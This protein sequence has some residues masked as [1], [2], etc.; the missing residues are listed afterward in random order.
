MAHNRSDSE[1]GHLKHGNCV[2]VSNN[3]VGILL[4]HQVAKPMLAS[5]RMRDIWTIQNCP[6]WDCLG[7]L[8]RVSSKP[9]SRL[10]QLRQQQ[11]QGTCKKMIKWLLFVFTDYLS[12]PAMARS[13]Y[14]IHS[15]YS[16]FWVWISLALWSFSFYLRQ[17]GQEWGTLA[18]CCV[19]K[20]SIEVLFLPHSPSTSTILKTFAEDVEQSLVQTGSRKTSCLLWSNLLLDENSSQFP[21]TA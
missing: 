8:N 9:H 12:I 6:S 3:L 10:L 14:F 17:W 2:L 16:S 19:S 1:S 21:S 18:L 11:N 15:P 7:G 13:F 20:Q 4:R 5:G